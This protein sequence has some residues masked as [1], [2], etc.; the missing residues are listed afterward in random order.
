MKLIHKPQMAIAEA[1]PAGFREFVNVLATNL[2]LAGRRLVQT[3]QQVQQGGLASA[4]AADNGN[5]FSGRHLQR[6]VRENR[7]LLRTYSEGPEKL[8]I[9]SDI[10]LEV[11]PRDAVAIIASTP[12]VRPAMHARPG[13]S[14]PA[15]SWQGRHR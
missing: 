8:T 12:P 3:T 7:E 5:G 4:A 13:K 10:S 14:L 2:D 1:G 11:T 9:F 15:G 6:D